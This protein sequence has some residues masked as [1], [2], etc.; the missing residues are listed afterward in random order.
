MKRTGKCPKCGS[1]NIVRI[2]DN[3]FLDRQV[4]ILT[5]FYV[6]RYEIKGRRSK[7]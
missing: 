4:A 5:L 1:S 6:I 2:P 3:Q 7:S